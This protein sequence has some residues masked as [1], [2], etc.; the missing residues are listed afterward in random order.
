MRDTSTKNPAPTAHDAEIL[1]SGYTSWHRRLELSAIVAFLALAALWAY[2]VIA[3][4][5]TGA[6]PVRSV[7][8]VL[9]ALAAAWLASDFVSGLVHWAADNWGTPEWPIVGASLIRPFRHHHVDPHAM[10]EHDFIELNGNN[11]IVSLPVLAMALYNPFESTSAWLLYSTFIA[12]M[13]LWVFGTNQFHAWAHEDEVSPIVG[14]LQRSGVILDP[15]HHAIHHAAP[16]DRH[17]CITSGWM[18]HVLE[19]VGFFA[20][21]EKLITGISGV[22]PAHHELAEKRS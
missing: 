21:L 2:K 1:A 9:A 20:G 6:A 14:A 10:C 16:H 4:F 5:A 17:Y 19:G 11:C 18:N 15:K 7:W 12:G 8:L 3:L 13:C 22:R